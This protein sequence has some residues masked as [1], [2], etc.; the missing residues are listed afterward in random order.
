MFGK[1]NFNFILRSFF[2]RNTP[3]MAFGYVAEQRK[4]VEQIKTDA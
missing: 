4:E 2:T 1:A 3:K